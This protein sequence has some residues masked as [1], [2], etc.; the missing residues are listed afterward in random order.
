MPPPASF[1][2]RTATL[3]LQVL[4]LART[5]MITKSDSY[6]PLLLLICECITILLLHICTDDHSLRYTHNTAVDTGVQCFQRAIY[7]LTQLTEV[8]EGEGAGKIGFG[9]LCALWLRSC[10]NY[11][12]HEK[13]ILLAVKYKHRNIEPYSREPMEGTF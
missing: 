1:G 4:V 12:V 5:F 11:S 8:F 7:L 13:G 6:V 9:W 10:R 3:T 2:L